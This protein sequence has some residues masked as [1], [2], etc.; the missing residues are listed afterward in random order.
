MPT[1]DS[2]FR[3]AS[4]ELI[5]DEVR[6]G[7]EAIRGDDRYFDNVSAD[8]ASRGTAMPSMFRTMASHKLAHQRAQLRAIER[9][10]L[11]LFRRPLAPLSLRT[12]VQS[13]IDEATRIVNKWSA[14]G[15]EAAIVVGAA[16]TTAVDRARSIAAGPARTGAVADPGRSATAAAP[17]MSA[18]TADPTSAALATSRP[19]YRRRGLTADSRRRIAEMQKRFEA[20]IVHRRAAEA[21]QI[22]AAEA[23]RRYSKRINVS[24]RPSNERVGKRTT[25]I[26]WNC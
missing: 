5:A 26:R 10:A 21:A 1:R 11:S 24:S 14:A 9:E 15:P 22:K 6:T 25:S 8:Y 23:Q 16:P 17:A 3:E 20:A 18:A 2:G 4:F 12:G 19:P 13:A 7:L